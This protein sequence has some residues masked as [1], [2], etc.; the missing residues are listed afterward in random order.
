M[1]VSNR[2][3]NCLPSSK[4][5]VNK[6]HVTGELKVE[7]LRNVHLCRRGRWWRSWASGCGKT[8]LLNCISGIDD[9]MG[10]VA[11]GRDHQHG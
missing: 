6:T 8:T 4:R 2:L 3:Q 7:A 10:Q 11:E 9:V 5:D 1:G